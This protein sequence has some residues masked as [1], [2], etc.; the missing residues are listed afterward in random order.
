[1]KPTYPACFYKDEESGGY[2]VEVPDLPGCASGGGN[3]A[4]AIIMGTDAAS[5]WALTWLE[6]GRALP[7]P[8]P[9]EAIKPAEDSGFVSVLVLDLGRI[10]QKAWAK[11]NK[12]DLEIH[13]Y[14]A[15]FAE[16]RRLDISKI[17]QDALLDLYQKQP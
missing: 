14:L 3:L 13:A 8:S 5:G 6:K 15:T 10:C 1:M 16:S 12:L 11:S 2:A 9:T 4:D 7:P 17:A